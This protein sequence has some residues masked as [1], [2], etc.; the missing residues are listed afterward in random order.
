MLEDVPCPLCGEADSSTVYSHVH[1]HYNGLAGDF[2]VVR[3]RSCGFVYTNPRPTEDTIGHFYPDSAGYFSPAAPQDPGPMDILFESYLADVLGYPSTGGDR[4]F[5]SK[6]LRPYCA[7][8]AKITGIP[9]FVSGGRLLDVGCSYGRYLSKMAAYGW[10]VYGI[11]P[12]AAAAE[13]AMQV[14]GAG[15]VHNGTIATAPWQDSFFDV[16]TLNMSLEHCHTPVKVL[17]KASALLKNDGV[18]IVSVPNFAGFESKLHAQFA[19][20]L[21]APCHL[22]HFT[23]QTLRMAGEKSGLQCTEIVFHHVDRDFVA[24]F[25]YKKNV[26]LSKLVHARLVRKLLIKPAVFIAARMGLTSRMTAYFKK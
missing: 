2:A 22:S 9:P 1:D 19:Y 6:V 26:Y 5:L 14:C 12:H 11:E 3:C 16:I 17:Q 21:H 7:L 18:L 24:P 8:R 25:E 4:P 15:N 23:P 20:T 13:V 10:S